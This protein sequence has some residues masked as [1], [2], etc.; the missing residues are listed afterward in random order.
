[1]TSKCLA[2]AASLGASIDQGVILAGTSAGGCIAAVSAHQPSIKGKIKGVALLC[3]H[4]VDSR[5]V[6]E[7]YK[8]HYKSFAEFEDGKVLDKKGT[9]WYDGTRWHHDGRSGMLM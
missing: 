5:G 4:L 6:P 7:K 2:N 3:P 9:D 8:E 1:M